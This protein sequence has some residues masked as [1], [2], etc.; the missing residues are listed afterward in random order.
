MFFYV[1]IIVLMYF[2]DDSDAAAS[3]TTVVVAGRLTS[4]VVGVCAVAT[5]LLGVFPAPALELA[6]QA[7]KFLS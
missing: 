3:G 5:I 1:R 4:V 6:Q 7:A 2:T